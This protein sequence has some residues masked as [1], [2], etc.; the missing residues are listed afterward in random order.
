[1]ILISHTDTHTQ[2]ITTISNVFRKRKGFLSSIYAVNFISSD[3][4]VAGVCLGTWV[5]LGTLTN[6]SS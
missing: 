3:T 6:L 5:T 4:E 2:T 1:M